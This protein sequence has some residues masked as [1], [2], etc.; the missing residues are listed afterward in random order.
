MLFVER[1]SRGG[2]FSVS[3]D[4]FVR[5]LR[6]EFP[7]TDYPQLLAGLALLHEQGAL[8]LLWHGPSDFVVSTTRRGR[9][10]AA[11]LAEAAKLEAAAKAEPTT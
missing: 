1:A 11:Q 10:L 9:E 4:G 6:S 7:E 8:V 5:N 3:R 2:K